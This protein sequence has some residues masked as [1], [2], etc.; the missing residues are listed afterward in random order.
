MRRIDGGVAQKKGMVY[1]PN[2]AA[3]EIMDRL[4]PSSVPDRKWEQRS[5]AFRKIDNPK[6]GR[7]GNIY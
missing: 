5:E 2:I 6:T 1:K 3:M 7:D 4:S